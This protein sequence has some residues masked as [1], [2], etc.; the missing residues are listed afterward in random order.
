MGNE[1]KKQWKEWLEAN[2]EWVDP[3]VNLF[4]NHPELVGSKGANQMF[5]HDLI[6]I[7]VPIVIKKDLKR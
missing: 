2:P 4:R 5:W 6:N 1:T 3:L 7:L